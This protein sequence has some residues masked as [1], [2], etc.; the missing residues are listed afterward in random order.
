MRYRSI[1]IYVSNAID[2]ERR[3]RLAARLSSGEPVTV[4]G[5]AISGM[6]RFMS[7]VLPAVTGSAGETL[8]GTMLPAEEQERREK[9]HLDMTASLERFEV[10]AQEF[11]IARIQTLRVDDDAAAALS[12]YGNTADLIILGKSEL[13]GVDDHKDSDFIEFVALNAAAAV[14]MVS[15]KP[16][17]RRHALIAWN[18]SSA[19][20]RAV[21][22]A[23]PLLQD[24]DAVS[25]VIFGDGMVPGTGVS[26]S[27][28]VLRQ[29]TASLQKPVV[30]LHRPPAADVGHALLTLAAELDADLIVMGCVAHPRWRGV[31]LGGTTGVV[32]AES[33]V[34]L[35]LSR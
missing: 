19:A 11:G 26:A 14:F 27:E 13:H 31:L 25:A 15:E 6:S 16:F 4:I 23:I 7:Q 35:L 22:N 28:E 12:N 9:K 2:L 8:P 5:L 10:L 29:C 21:R 1:L 3:V 24:V 33:P 18:S 17:C 30:I 20:S 32:I 34:S